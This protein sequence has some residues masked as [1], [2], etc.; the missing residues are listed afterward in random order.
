M[1]VFSLYIPVY[2]FWHF[3]DFSWGNTRVVVGEGGK[4]RK[5][6]ADVKE[7]RLKPSRG[8]FH[9]KK[10]L[11]PSPYATFPLSLSTPSFFLV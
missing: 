6:T 3:D 1:P 9:W 4:V 10:F 7:V 11:N 2:S 8:K 5:Y